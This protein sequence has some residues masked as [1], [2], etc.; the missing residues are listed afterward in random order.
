MES[1]RAADCIQRL[2]REDSRGPAPRDGSH[3]HAG[4]PVLSLLNG[5]VDGQ[6]GGKFA[7]LTPRWVDLQT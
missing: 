4:S 7:D 5:E 3:P 6:P 1:N 2:E